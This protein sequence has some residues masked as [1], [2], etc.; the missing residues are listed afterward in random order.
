[1][2]NLAFYSVNKLIPFI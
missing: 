1:M 2:I